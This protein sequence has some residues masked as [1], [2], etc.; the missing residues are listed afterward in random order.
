LFLAQVGQK[1]QLFGKKSLAK[2]VD[3]RAV[4]CYSSTRQIY[5][6]TSERGE[7]PM[8]ECTKEFQ[9]FDIVELW[10]TPTKTNPV[11][12]R[13]TVK[14]TG[15]HS[16]S[17]GWFYIADGP[18]PAKCI[19]KRFSWDFD[20]CFKPLGTYNVA[21]YIKLARSAEHAADARIEGLEN[22]NRELKSILNNIHIRTS[23]FDKGVKP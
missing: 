17:K 16:D 21:E 14:L 15:R 3:L 23:G 1:V 13:G 19:G 12:Y 18:D 6:W 4:L 10:H 9:S 8:T 2:P 22:E 5:F 7:Q 11:A 20:D